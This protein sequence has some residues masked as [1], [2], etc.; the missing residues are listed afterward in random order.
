MFKINKLNI[1]LPKFPE[2]QVFDSRDI[3]SHSH[4]QSKLKPENFFNII[5]KDNLSEI[6]SSWNLACLNYNCH[7]NKFLLLDIQTNNSFYRGIICGVSSKTLNKELVIPHEKVFKKKVKKLQNYLDIVKIQAEPVVFGTSFSKEINSLIKSS[8]L[9]KPIIDFNYKNINYSI[10]YFELNDSINKFSK[11]YIVDGHHRTSSFKSFSK[12]YQKEHQLLTFLTD[13]KDVK[14]DKFTWQVIDPSRHLI[15]SI[16]N[17][18]K[19]AFKPDNQLFWAMYKNEYYV[20][21]KSDL[22]N[23]S[24]INLEKWIIKSGD[25]IK[26]YY[27]VG[28]KKYNYSNGI[29]FNFPTLTFNQIIDSINK[30]EIFPQKSTF[31]EPKMLTGLTISELV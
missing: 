18:K 8:I 1:L 12:E 7:L 22:K 5:K 14:S 3:D 30:Q 15:N 25:K 29:V 26:R 13:I 4:N 11:F 28:N 19:T 2:N 16:R 31:L 17:L 23:L 10:R 24:I 21:N 9:N 6:R 20:F 27:T